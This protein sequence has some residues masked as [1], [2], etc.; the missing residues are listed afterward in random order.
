[1][2]DADLRKRLATAAFLA[3]DENTL[4]AIH[5][6]LMNIEGGGKIPLTVKYD[7]SMS[8]LGEI[9]VDII[10]RCNLTLQSHRVSLTTN[11]SQLALFGKVDKVPDKKLVEPEKK[12]IKPPEKVA[13][14]AAAKK[15]AVKKKAKRKTKKSPEPEAKT[16]AS[17]RAG[18]VRGTGSAEERLAQISKNNDALYRDGVID[19]T[20]AK[21]AGVDVD[22]IDG[23]KDNVSSGL[24]KEEL[25]SIAEL[26]G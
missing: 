21:M 8:D 5:D 26:S 1:M 15:E 22:A 20:Q 16:E 17:V 7:F 18:L 3:I 6:R 10:A 9:S 4:D 2:A 13:K 14:K 19:R 11:G 12:A 23:V 25:E 24:T